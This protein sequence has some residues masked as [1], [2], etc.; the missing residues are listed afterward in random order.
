VSL[1]GGESRRVRL[2]VEPRQLSYWDTDTDEFRVR[3]GE[4]GVAVS[5]SSRAL[6]LRAT[7]R[8]TE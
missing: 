1:A 6:P 2:S 7:Y 5:S 3:Q 8:V 4:Y